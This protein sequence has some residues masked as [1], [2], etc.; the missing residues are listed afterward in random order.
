ILVLIN[1]LAPSVNVSA[2]I[3]AATPMNIPRA[4]SSERKRLAQRA[5][6]ALPKLAP[7]IEPRLKPRPRS[8]G[9]VYIDGSAFPARCFAGEV[10]GIFGCVGLLKV[11][12]PLPQP[13]PHQLLPSMQ[14][15][16][17]RPSEVQE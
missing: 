5:S 1:A 8:C 2:A 10:G 15:I 12:P 4:V 9:M 17:R 6:K 11:F 14:P 3:T 7:I 13:C 16:H